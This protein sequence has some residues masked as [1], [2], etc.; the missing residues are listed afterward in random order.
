MYNW[1]NT[2]W[3]FQVVCLAKKKRYSRLSGGYAI[4]Y[5]RKKKDTGG[6]FSLRAEKKKVPVVCLAG[7]SVF[8]SGGKLAIFLLWREIFITTGKK[9]VPVVC[10]AGCRLR[11]EKKKVLV[12]WAGN[13]HYERKKKKFQSSVWRVRDQLRPEKKKDTGGKFSL[14][15]EKKK[16]PVVCLA[17][18]RSITT[19]K[20]KR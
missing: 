10:L 13:F 17:G 18:T 14:R 5:D 2:F 15:A 20:K 1:S 19:G 4:N 16:V 8:G 3:K 7:V 12:V 6:K 9:K 11:P